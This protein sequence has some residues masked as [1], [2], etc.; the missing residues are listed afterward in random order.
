KPLRDKMADENVLAPAPIRSDDQI[1]TFATWITP[2]DQA[3]QFVSPPS[4]DAIID[5]VN[6]L[7]YTED[8]ASGNIVRESLYPA[9]ADTDKTNSGGD[10]E[11][12]QIDEE[13]GKYVNNQVNLEEKTVELDQGQV[14]SDPGKTLESQ[15]PP[16][17]EF[18]DEDRLDQTLDKVVLKFPVNDVIIEDPLSLT[19]TLSSMKNL[20]DAYTI[21]DQFLNDRSTEDEP[22]KLNVEA[23]VVSMVTVPIYQAS[24]SVPPLSTPI[25]DLSPPKLDLT[26]KIKQTVNEAVK[27]VV[28][29]ALQASLRDH[30]KEL[31][32]AD[33]KEILHQRMFESGSYKLLPE[34]VALY[35]A[36]EASME[37]E[38]RDEFVAKKDKSRK[39]R[40][41]VNV[42]DS[43]DTDT[44][45]LPKIKTRPDWLKPLP[46]EDRPETPELDYIIPLTDLPDAENKWVDA[47]G[48]SYK[49]PE[50]NKLLNQTG[51]ID[52]ARTA[53]LSISKVMAANY[54]DFR[55]EELVPSLWIESECDYNNIVAYSITHWWFKHKDF[56]IT[57]H[58]ALSDRR[59][60]RS[61]M[62]ILSVISIK[63]FERYR[64]AFLREIVIRR[65]DY[66]EYKIFEADF[67]NMHPNDFEDMYLLHL[68]GKL[69]H[70]PRSN[71][72]H[73]YN[74]INLWIRKIV[75]RQRMGDLDRN[76]RKKMLRDNEVHKF[77]DGTLTRVLHKLDHMVKDFRLYQY[78]LGMEYRIWFEDD[79]RRSEEFMEVIKR[80]LK[81]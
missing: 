20:D 18:M 17:Q 14:G 33:M 48:K 23:E 66:N 60:V 46:E 38:N 53:A 76:D 1:L 9:D 43:E 44:A 57:R 3:H 64:Y 39:R 25:I 80:R 4:G 58:N 15:R 47:L 78:N 69:N 72:V 10:T 63:T 16:E 55:L 41:D 30:F 19:G 71:K 75:I 29:I 28:H 2:T 22:K 34:H 68:Q 12:L 27:E 65:A 50:E 81:I 56:Y 6:E 40:R 77:S 61:H 49:D 79:K 11:I 13:Q 5:F 8:D 74:A 52:T 24:L 70:L 73:L 62:Q 7:G 45:H 32:E 67:K 35:E 37:R 21:R 26:H 31:L 51:D 42:S 59:A 54:P 36:L